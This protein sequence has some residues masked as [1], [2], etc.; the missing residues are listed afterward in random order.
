[1]NMLDLTKKLEL[2]L[3]KAEIFT[4]PIMAVK[5]AVD[6]SGSMSNEFRSGWVQNT[7]DLFLAA[8]MKFD[9]DG[10][11]EIGFFNSDF[12]QT[13]DMT[14][15]D[16]GSY[17]QKHGIRADGGTNFAA[18]VRELK[19]SSEAKKGLFSFF[20][21]EPKKPTPVYL[22]LITD[23]ENGDKAAFEFQLRSLDNTFVQIV[24]IGSGVNK[25]YL[26]S[27]AQ[28]YDNVS[29]IYLTNPATVTPDSFYE[30]LLNTELK[31]FIKE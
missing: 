1:M 19:G 11:M 6:K 21:A 25:H 18:A 10:K 17:I 24:A 20:R 31:A 5:L 30:Q 4:V 2:N 28:N 15:A 29:V 16:A 22:A 23:G 27:V 12:T 8:A 14:V 7:L 9:D 13:P 26:D 3:I